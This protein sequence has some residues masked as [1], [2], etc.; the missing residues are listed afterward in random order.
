[1]VPWVNFFL[2]RNVYGGKNIRTGIDLSE[3][4]KPTHLF[5]LEELQK[6]VQR[7]DLRD[8]PLGTSD[9]PKV[10]D[11]LC[12]IHVAHPYLVPI[13]LLPE[14]EMCTALHGRRFCGK[15]L[16]LGIFFLE[17]KSVIPL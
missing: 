17:F 5:F 10:L 6:S 16:G 8:F 15:D 7:H 14:T 4:R 9:F 11:L 2:G 12:V 3:E 13:L 1:M